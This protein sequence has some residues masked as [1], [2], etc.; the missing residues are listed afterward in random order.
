ML[1][2]PTESVGA[3][4]WRKLNESVQNLNC[5]FWLGTKCL[6]APHVK[7]HNCTPSISL[8]ANFHLPLRQTKPNNTGKNDN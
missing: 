3:L 8:V 1:D 2:N 6:L 5:L 7:I 4:T